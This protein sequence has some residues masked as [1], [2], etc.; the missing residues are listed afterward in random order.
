MDSEGKPVEI[1]DRS[2][3]YDT[4]DELKQEA[5]TN[6]KTLHLESRSPYITLVLD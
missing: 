3:Y 2:F 1:S 4:L 6:L 5:K